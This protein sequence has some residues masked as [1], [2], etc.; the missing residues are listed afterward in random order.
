[1]CSPEP[2]RLA[3]AVL[4]CHQAALH[5]EEVLHAKK[6]AYRVQLGYP[7]IALD[8]AADAVSGITRAVE[9]TVHQEPSHRGA[10]V[11]YRLFVL[12]EKNW[13]PTSDRDINMGKR[14]APPA[15]DEAEL[16]Q[17]KSGER[18][19]AKQPKLAPEA[20]GFKNKEK[21]LL[22]SSRGITHRSALACS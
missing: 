1:V 13:R 21:V 10:E 4:W 19:A 5:E 8:C 11:T 7:I 3:S 17:S 18:K 22:L 14:K 2:K 20:S 6:L 9:S 15:A 16:Q 12:G